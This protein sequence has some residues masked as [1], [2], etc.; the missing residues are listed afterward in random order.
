MGVV[1]I[2]PNTGGNLSG[3]GAIHIQKHK[4]T[5]LDIIPVLQSF[6][7][8][9]IPLSAFGIGISWNTC[10]LYCR[11]NSYHSPTA[12]IQEPILYNRWSQVHVQTEETAGSREASKGPAKSEG[13]L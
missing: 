12:L 7:A 9:A 6:I 8:G 3:T 10:N 11:V 2:G 1:I 4:I 13:L 5:Y